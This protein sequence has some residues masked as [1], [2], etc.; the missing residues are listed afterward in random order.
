MKTD[1]LFEISEENEKTFDVY[2]IDEEKFLAIPWAVIGIEMGKGALA[3]LGGKI[4]QSIFFPDSGQNVKIDFSTLITELVQKFEKLLKESLSQNEL[5]KLNA[6]LE[7]IQQNMIHYMN[8]PQ[9]EDRLSDSTNRITNT[10]AQLK[11]LNKLGFQSYSIAANMQFLIIQE[12]IKKYGNNE[13]ANLREAILRAIDH[14]DNTRSLFFDWHHA[15][16]TN[17]RR[18]GSPSNGTYYYEYD[19]RTNSINVPQLKQWYIDSGTPLRPDITNFDD[20]FSLHYTTIKAKSWREFSAENINP[21]STDLRKIW[22]QLRKSI[23]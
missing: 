20:A 1:K 22:N 15:R 3:Y 13:K 8:N 16:Y 9:Q 18:V 17:P 10:L 2:F 11:S 12:R 6:E 23:R 7:S 21:I 19:G 14:V 4:F 5:R